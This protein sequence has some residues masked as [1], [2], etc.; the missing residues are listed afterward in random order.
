MTAKEI[1]REIMKTRGYTLELLREKLGYSGVTAVANRL[2]S[3]TTKD[4]SVD[5]LVKFTAAMDCE[6][7]IRSKKTDKQEWVVKSCDTAIQ[8]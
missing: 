4:M 3:K 2:N 5:T 1:V 8:E 7:V 6:V